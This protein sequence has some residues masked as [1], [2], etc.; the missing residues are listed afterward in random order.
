MEKYLTEDKRVWEIE[1][2]LSED[3]L[4]LFQDHISKT[5]WVTKED[6]S[7]PLW[8][9]NISIFPNFNFVVKKVNDI[10]GNQYRW[11]SMGI[12]M[13][14]RVGS[15]MNPHVDN[16]N[17]P[18]DGINNKFMSAT[19]YLND[20]FTGGELYYSKLKIDYTPKRGSIVFH[21]GFENL[22]EH[23]VREVGT[24][25]RYAVGLVGKSLT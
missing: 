24:T 8:V 20:D 10:T 25:D 2:F 4:R 19:L 18:K 12:I 7:N 17:S 15:K 5:E 11:N 3:E 23:G 21:P 22:Y 16:Y 6:W 14:I 13:R 9:N 1:N